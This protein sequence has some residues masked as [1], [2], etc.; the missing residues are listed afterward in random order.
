MADTRRQRIQITLDPSTLAALDRVGGNRSA[1]IE[2]AILRYLEA[3]DAPPEPD[4]A[5]L[6]AWVQARAEVPQ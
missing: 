2:A 1:L 3:P 6:W 5:A 4:W